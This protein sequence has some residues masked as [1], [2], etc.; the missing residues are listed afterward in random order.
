[1][2]NMGY[3]RSVLDVSAHEPWSESPQGRRPRQPDLLPI[4]RP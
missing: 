3:R 4:P 2:S 1:M